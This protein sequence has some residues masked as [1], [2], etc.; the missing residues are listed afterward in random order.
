[1][2]ARP[3]SLGSS[4]RLWRSFPPFAQPPRHLPLRS[5]A[6]P[7]LAGAGHRL[8]PGLGQQFVGM[9]LAPSFVFLP[10]LGAAGRFSNESMATQMTGWGMMG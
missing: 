2:R 9:W 10:V 1:L 7:E 5:E 8:Q 4:S 3:A 6:S